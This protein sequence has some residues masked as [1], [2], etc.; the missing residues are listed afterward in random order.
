MNGM[1]EWL[2]AHLTAIGRY[3]T[4]GVRRGARLLRCSQCR[5]QVLTGLDGDRCAMAVM[6]EP[7]EIDE[8]GEALALM[9]GL[10]TYTL[11]QTNGAK[12]VVWNIDWRPSCALGKQRWHALLTEHRCEMAVPPTQHPLLAQRGPVDAGAAAPF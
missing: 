12:G 6:C 5:R 8:K 4:D 7:Y 3:D 9:L 1:P 2:V 10:Q 11:T